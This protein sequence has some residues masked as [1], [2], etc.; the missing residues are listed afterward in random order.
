MRPLAYNRI[1]AAAA[2]G[3]NT[4]TLDALVADGRIHCTRVG[5]RRLF[6]I[7]EL[8]RFLTADNASKTN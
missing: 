4:R 5:R 7:V 8:E 3:I 2:L 1:E 6:A